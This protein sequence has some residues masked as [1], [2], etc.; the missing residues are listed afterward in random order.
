MGRVVY[1]IRAR[2]GGRWGSEKGT[3]IDRTWAREGGSRRRMKADRHVALQ[4]AG[5]GLPRLCRLSVDS[6]AH[7]QSVRMCPPSAVVLCC[8][9]PP[10]LGLFTK[11]AQSTD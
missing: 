7:F 3:M 8:P 9:P 10:P 6:V 11:R 4:E 2:R 1:G 5:M